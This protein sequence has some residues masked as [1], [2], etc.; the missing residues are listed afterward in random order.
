MWSAHGG[1]W[2]CYATAHTA[3]LI[4]RVKVAM[5]VAEIFP[6]ESQRGHFAYL[7]KVADVAVKMD[8]HKTLYSFYTTKKM[9]Q[10]CTCSIRIY[11]EIFSKRPV[12]ECATKVYFLSI[13][14]SF[15]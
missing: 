7:F 13:R 11:F 5:S 6:G 4:E 14:Y 15:C 3:K 1:N 2:P 10:E 9:S 8:L 12:Y